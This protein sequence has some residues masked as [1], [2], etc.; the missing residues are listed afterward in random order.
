MR[1]LMFIAAVILA[2]TPVFYPRAATVEEELARAR[3]NVR[4]AEATVAKIESD[5]K[6]MEANPA[7]DPEAVAA[8]KVYLEKVRK[9]RDEH[10]KIL[11]RMEQM[12]TEAGVVLDA[13]KTLATNAVED[14]NITLKDPVTLDEVELMEQELN[15]ALGEYD[16]ILR[17]SQA[18]L[19]GKM[20]ELRANSSS[21]LNEMAQEA[22]A[23]AGKSGGSGGSGGAGSSGAQAGTS[24]GAGESA[25]G[26]GK[27]AETAGGEKTGGG[28]GQ[29]GGENGGKPGGG[30]E[31]AGQPGGQPGGGE[32]GATAGAGG[33]TKGGEPGG[34]NTRPGST[35]PSNTGAQK[36]TARPGAEDD[37][38]VARQLREAAEQEK[39]PVLKEKLW[40][41]YDAYKKGSK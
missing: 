34:A 5:L 38:I 7:S 29:P 3:E 37:D 39:D 12:A 13:P 40:K 6:K 8:R 26:G 23:A 24:G 16:G 1:L 15:R 28:A 35:A 18:E 32:E 21:A 11:A 41:E 9:L 33:E 19:A 27:G 22:A 30:S 20:Q 4:I 31:T 2:V 17:K 10:R 14:V 25:G 36:P